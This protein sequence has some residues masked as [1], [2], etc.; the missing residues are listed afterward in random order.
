MIVG[1]V[2]ELRRFPVKSVGGE[3]PE[4]VE[5]DHRGVVDDR[6]WAVYTADGGIGSGKTTRRFRRVD[7]LLR[8]SSDLV[9]G[10]AVLTD[11]D[12]GRWP[13]TDAATAAELSRWLGRPVTVRE[14]STVPHR[15]DAPVHL[16]TTASLRGVARLTGT[17]PDAGR[18]RANVLLEV[19]GDGFPEDGWT[20]RR[21]LLG[22][23]VVLRL[24]EP[25]PR[26]VMVDADQVGVA[27]GPPVLRALGARGV[28][29]GLMADVERP[30]RVA[31]GDVARLD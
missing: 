27:P 10:V 11:P 18:F 16:L 21:L 14:E 25:M 23:E 13:V 15:D 6:R 30:G 2:G 26:C 3:R 31:V 19:P 29:L 9:D 1:R 20:G 12:G 17:R 22:D 7:G 24:G 8:W 4:S 5:V 28:E